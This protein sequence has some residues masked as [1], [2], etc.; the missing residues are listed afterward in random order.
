MKWGNVLG[1]IA[2][3]GC[4]TSGKQ[5]WPTVPE[6]K[7]RFYTFIE[8]YDQRYVDSIAQ[9]GWAWNGFY[10][11]NDRCRRWVLYY[12]GLYITK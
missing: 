8:G 2:T 6:D 10:A 9:I 4:S 3:S 11:M 7:Y 5:C 1:W 12:I